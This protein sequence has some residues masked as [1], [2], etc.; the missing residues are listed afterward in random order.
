MSNDCCSVVDISTIWFLVV[1]S[2]S[3]M[4]FRAGPTYTVGKRH[5]S[6]E[7]EEKAKVV[8]AVCGT[9]LIEVLAAQQI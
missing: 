2:L 7:E 1:T 6:L 5:K 4:F 8:T 9:E 3:R